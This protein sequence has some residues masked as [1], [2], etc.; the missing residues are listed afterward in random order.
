MTDKHIEN[1]QP[2]SK[3]ITK[4]CLFLAPTDCKWSDWE[5]GQ[6]TKTCGGGKRTNYRK[7]LVQQSNGGR[8]CTGPTSETKSCNTHSCP[9]GAYLLFAL[10]ITLFRSILTNNE[11]F[12]ALTQ[13]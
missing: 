1:L 12:Y 10:I 3:C 5:Y 13:R 8:P 2:S 7:K 11:F 6:C 9:I 4:F